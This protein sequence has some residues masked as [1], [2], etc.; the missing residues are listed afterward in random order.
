MINAQEI[1]TTFIRTRRDWN[2]SPVKSIFMKRSNEDV[3]IYQGQINESTNQIDYFRR[4]G[5]LVLAGAILF[6]HWAAA[7]YLFAVGAGGHSRLPS[8]PSGLRT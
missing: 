1:K 8:D 5:L 6:T 3:F 7:P 2:V 4:R